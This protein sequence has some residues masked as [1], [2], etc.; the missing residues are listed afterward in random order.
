MLKRGFLTPI[1]KNP[2]RPVQAVGGFRN[3]YYV[4]PDYLHTQIS[5]QRFSL[6]GQALE[7]CLYSVR[8]EK[9]AVMLHRIAA[10][11]KQVAQAAH[12]ALALR[13]LRVTRIL[14]IRPERISSAA[15]IFHQGMDS[16]SNTAEAD[17]PNTG[18]SKA[19]G[20]TSEAE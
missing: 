10:F 13:G 16:F 8:V 15:V 4:L 7:V 5:C 14:M 9:H 12:Q 1:G 2:R 3:P 17:I 19:H 6:S 20:V 11:V 18:T